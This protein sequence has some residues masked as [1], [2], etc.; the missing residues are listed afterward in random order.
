MEVLLDGARVRRGLREDQPRIAEFL[1]LNG[2]SRW[3]VYEE[4]FLVAER[5]GRVLAALRYRTEKKRLLLGL[6]VTDPWA[7]ERD[8][9]VALYAGVGELAREPLS[10]PDSTS[11]SM[12]SWT[13]C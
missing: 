10:A 6:L 5:D 11:R 8:L 2:L 3:I 13:C 9:A 12:A 7:G 4:T 1:E